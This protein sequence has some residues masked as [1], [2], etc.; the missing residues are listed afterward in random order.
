MSLSN[1]Q[2]NERTNE[3]TLPLRFIVIAQIQSYFFSPM[4]HQ[5]AFNVTDNNRTVY[6]RLNK[7]VSKNQK[8]GKYND[9]HFIHKYTREIL[10]QSNTYCERSFLHTVSSIYIYISKFR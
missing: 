2:T 8:K 10:K 1:E 7:F 5:K 9:I 3:P 6:C 4:T